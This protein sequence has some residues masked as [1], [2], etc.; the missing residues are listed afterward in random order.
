MAST[1]GTNVVADEQ[2]YIKVLES[3]FSVLENAYMKNDE[4]HKQMRMMDQLRH[5]LRAN[6]QIAYSLIPQQ[7]KDQVVEMLEAQSI[8]YMALPDSKGNYM[9]ITRD[10]DSD[11]FMQ[12]QKDVECLS[13]EYVRELTPQN[14]LAL[15][16]SH[17]IKNVDTLHF[18]N[19]QMCEIAKEKLYQSGVPFAEVP[20]ENGKGYEL[21]VSPTGKFSKD[22]KDLSSFELQHAYEQ[23][24][25]DPMF[26]GV[27]GK[28]STFMNVR[29]AQAK[30]DNEQ[31]NK[32]A[33]CALRGKDAVL[34]S[35]VGKQKICIQSDKDGVHV[36][37][38]SDGKWK[39]SD[40]AIDPKATS[41]DIVSLISK[42]TD[43]I[44]DKGV[45]TSKTAID[46]FEQI[47]NQNLKKIKGKTSEVGYTDQDNKAHS[48]QFNSTSGF[49]PDVDIITKTGES[50]KN[51]KN[52]QSISSLQIEPML[53]AINAEATRIVKAQL[54]DGVY[55]KE[56]AYQMKHDAIC[57]IM[58]DKEL[59]QIQEF[60]K[61]DERMDKASREKWFDNI[62]EHFEN[63]E[64]N[65]RYS[66]DLG[67]VSVKDMVSQFAKGQENVVSME[68]DK[69]IDLD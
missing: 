22:G 11:R 34:C 15:Y 52:Y 53:K 55:S 2:Q 28:V 60:L 8:P 61:G 40:L 50:A 47:K 14:M 62:C 1:I 44:H 58:H 67:K 25:A 3:I 18:K 29:L 42:Y 49:R 43:Q 66:C 19:A 37:E 26:K 45:L 35:M 20:L 10:S 65:T 68:K 12:I 57:D 39:T 69:D 16:K 32:F 54:G 17:G 64:E 41:K 46:D 24:K 30:Y 7:F 4:N 56:R 63:T 36:L 6:G 5:H 27:N 31:M 48:V 13:T 38:N 33:Q 9:I 23:S 59:P 51:I 21:I